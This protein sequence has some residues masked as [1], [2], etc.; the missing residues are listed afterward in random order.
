MM[1][2]WPAPSPSPITPK[3]PM[4][5]SAW[6]PLQRKMAPSLCTRLTP[7]CC[8][9]VAMLNPT[10][11]SP[12]ILPVFEALTWL[13]L[14]LSGLLLFLTGR[15]SHID[16]LHPQ[17]HSFYRWNPGAL[18]TLCSTRLPSAEQQS[19]RGRSVVSYCKLDQPFQ[20]D[21]VWIPLA[22]LFWEYTNS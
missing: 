7:S 4:L 20:L 8:R 10:S 18:S 21:S 14:F 17:C 13:F 19:D 9:S 1:A 5:S 2:S 3:P 12:H 15:E 22:Q 11:N 6:S 16:S